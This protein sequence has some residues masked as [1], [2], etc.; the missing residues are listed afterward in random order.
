[1][2]NERVLIVEDDKELSNI[3]KEF[4]EADGFFVIQAFYG[5][6]GI[7]KAKQEQPNLILLDIMLPQVDGIEVCRRIRT[8]SHAPIIIIS[9][10]NSDYDKVISL[11]VG[12]DDYLTKPFSQ[13]EMVA[14]VKSHLRRYTMFSGANEIEEKGQEIKC[15]TYGL[16]TIDPKR[17]L[18]LV[19]EREISF[20]SKEFRLL[21]F[22]SRH[23]GFVFSKEQLIDHVWGYSEYIDDNTVAVYIGRVREK[24]AKEGIQAIKTVWGVGYKWD[25]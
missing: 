14:R 3:M 5:K 7:E 23:P 6:D 1:M 10:K 4:L 20:T 13:V 18:V 22:L 15:R 19:H 11:G 12:A 21:D 24:L 16:L 2:A 8:Y 17:F 25:I 9:A